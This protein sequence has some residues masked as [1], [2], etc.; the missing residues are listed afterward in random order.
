MFD[1]GGV[2]VEKTGAAG[3]AAML[4]APPEPG[5]LWRKWLRSPPGRRV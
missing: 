4:P 2:L 1:L 5:E 3:L